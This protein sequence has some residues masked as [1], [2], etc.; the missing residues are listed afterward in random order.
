[1][2]NHIHGIIEFVWANNYSPNQS[3]P[4]QPL[5]AHQPLPHNFG[6]NDPEMGNGEKNI[7]MA[8]GR[9]IFRPYGGHH[10]KQLVPWF[11]GLKL[12][13]QNGCVITPML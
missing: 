8:N 3:L 12:G 10:Q 11:V 1:M 6:V 13:L 9:K 2:P 7:E 4:Q 5:L